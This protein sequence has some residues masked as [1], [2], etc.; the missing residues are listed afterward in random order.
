[1]DGL[2]FLAATVIAAASIPMAA[3]LAKAALNAL[4]AALERRGA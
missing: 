3:F 2:E 1:M 4:L